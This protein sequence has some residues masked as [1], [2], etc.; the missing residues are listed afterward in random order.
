MRRG[1]DDDRHLLVS[2]VRMCGEGTRVQIVSN[3]EYAEYMVGPS[4]SARKRR[5]AALQIRR[6]R[7]R[8]SGSESGS[9]GIIEKMSMM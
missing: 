6:E 1:G 8:G 4:A 9:R 2:A 7:E 3:D 5:T